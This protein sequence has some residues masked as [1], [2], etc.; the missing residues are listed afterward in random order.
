MRVAMR[1]TRDDSDVFAQ[2]SNLLGTIDPNAA[3]VEP[4]T[5][6]ALVNRSSS[7]FARKF[8]FILIGSFAVMALVLAL[9]GIYGVVSYGVSQQRRELGIRMALG[10]DARGVVSLFLKRSASMAGLG[11]IAGIAAAVVSARLV[12]GMLYG[13][14]PGDPMTYVGA[15]VLL[16]AA[17]L[18]A[19]LIPA[20]RAARVDPTTTLRAE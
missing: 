15:A 3:V 1:T 10:A 2:L 18:S 11:A 6:E 5:M 20:L 8:P 19:T 14:A 17:S 16:G 12:A 7:V 9:V 4:V 13:V